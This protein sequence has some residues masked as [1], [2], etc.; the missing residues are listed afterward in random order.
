MERGRLAEMPRFLSKDGTGRDEHEESTK[1][2]ANCK[3]VNETG[4]DACGFDRVENL[5]F[6]GPEPRQERAGPTGLLQVN[7]RVT[8][9]LAL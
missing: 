9:L 3:Q 1:D 8:C 2:Y 5:T 6:Q 7:S 4:A